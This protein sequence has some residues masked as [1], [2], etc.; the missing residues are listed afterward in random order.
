MVICVD[1]NDQSASLECLAKAGE[2]AWVIGA[3]E[4]NN[5][6]VSRVKFVS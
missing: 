2:T 4:G 6:N 5:S 3:I 1:K